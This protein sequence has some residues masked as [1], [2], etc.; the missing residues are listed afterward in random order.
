MRG[1]TECQGNDLIPPCFGRGPEGPCRSAGEGGGGGRGHGGRRYRG[2]AIPPIFVPHNGFEFIFL[3][4]S[5]GGGKYYSG[6]EYSR[7]KHNC[8][9]RNLRN[10]TCRK[11]AFFKKG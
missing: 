4:L 1:D 6:P 11:L 8:Q 7:I 9:N 5:R 3:S 10:K 2:Q